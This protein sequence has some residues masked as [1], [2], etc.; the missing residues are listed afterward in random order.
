MKRGGSD[1]EKMRGAKVGE[2]EMRSGDM[3]K[4]ES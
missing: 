4:N 1:V 3:M 2:N